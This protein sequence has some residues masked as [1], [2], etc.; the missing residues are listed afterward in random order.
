MFHGARGLILMLSFLPLA[1][2]IAARQG[3]AADTQQGEFASPMVLELPLDKLRD[4]APGGL[5]T[6]TDQQ[7]FVCDDASLTLLVVRKTVD[8]KAKR[9]ELKLESTVFVRPSYDR[10]VNLRFTVVREGR[11]LEGFTDQEIS[12]KEKEYR[13]DRSTL[14]LPLEAFEQALAGE[15]RGFLKVVMVVTPD[16]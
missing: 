11:A 7:K 3:T 12:A 6:F 9:V 16:R 4:E 15:P 10:T 14:V 8:R 1:G 13:S 2:Q 5:Y